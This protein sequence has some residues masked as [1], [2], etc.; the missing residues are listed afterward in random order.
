[1]NRS[2]LRTLA[3]RSLIVSVI[4]TALL[5]IVAVLLNRFDD[6]T[7]RI[8]LTSVVIS[9]SSLASLTC[10]TLLERRARH[11]LAIAG[12]VLSV[13]AG[14]LIVV[15]LWAR[16][17]AS[18][19]WR[20]TGSLGAVAICSAQICLLWLARPAPR[21]AWVQWA[22][23]AIWYGLATIV[24]WM[25][26]GEPSEELIRRPL[27]VVAI[28]AGTVTIVVPVLHKLNSSSA[29]TG[30][31]TVTLH[32]TCPDCGVGLSL[33]ME[34]GPRIVRI[35]TDEHRSEKEPLIGVHSSGTA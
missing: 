12:I 30:V 11:P 10:A 15:G 25:I 20:F 28:L 5:G 17:N 6:L 34:E 7:A 8:L 3:L 2:R 4:A 13:L 1:M 16:I 9:I 33:E 14:A 21:F 27:S 31:D 29:P 35:V 22:V 18:E 26:Y 23:F 24:V 19:Y 32:A